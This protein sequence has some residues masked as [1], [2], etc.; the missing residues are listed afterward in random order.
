MY[1]HLRLNSIFM[2]K[3][4]IFDFDGTIANT[5]PAAILILKR[6][7][8]SQYN[9]NIDEKFV[10]ELRDKPIPQIFKTLGIPLIKLPFIARK[11]RKELSRE[12]SGLKPIK[13]IRELLI[14]LKKDGQKIGILS[15]NSR[16]SIDMFLRENDL[17]IFDFIHTNSQ[18][19]GKAKSIN[20]LI[21]ENGW[22]KENV[23]YVGD[24][25]R[26][27]EAA[28]KTGIKIL[29]VTWGVN[30]KERLQAYSPDFIADKPEDLYS[31]YKTRN[32]TTNR[33]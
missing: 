20:K 1:N 14:K 2:I 18:I 29:A 16:E 25:I 22:D 10:E 24:E 30:S 5:I 32:T 26:D 27:I 12:V 17:E 4:T 31:L 7:G 28:R 8:L 11:A 33:K 21:K 6:L 3:I 9:I 23:A 19:F 13:G 15:S